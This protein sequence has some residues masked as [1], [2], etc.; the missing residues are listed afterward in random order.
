MKLLLDVEKTTRGRR[1]QRD[2]S[3]LEAFGAK[4]R[5]YSFLGLPRTHHRHQLRLHLHSSLPP[6]RKTSVTTLPRTLQFKL[7]NDFTYIKRY[8]LN[9]QNDSTSND[10]ELSCSNFFT[11]YVAEL[12]K[13]FIQQTLLFKRLKR[14]NIFHYS[15]LIDFSVFTSNIEELKF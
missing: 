3:R 9:F 1:H 4:S 8:S 10:T 13:P 15:C 12:K 2:S 11:S 7:L 6:S 14:L 5:F